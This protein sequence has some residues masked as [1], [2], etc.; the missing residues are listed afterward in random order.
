MSPLALAQL[1]ADIY[2]IT[3]GFTVYDCDGVYL[4]H[5]NIDNCDVFVF[6]GSANTEDWLDDFYAIPLKDPALGVVHSGM[7]RGVPEA[8]LWI[9]HMLSMLPQ[10]D[11]VILTGHSLGGAHARLMAGLLAADKNPATQLV[12][13]G[14][15]KPGCQLLKE[16]VAA[17]VEHLSYRHCE[18][19]V[20]TLPP[21]IFGYVHTEPWIELGQDP[22]SGILEPASD[23]SIHRY[24]EAL[25]NPDG[26]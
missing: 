25:G 23:H 9:K 15:P 22:D 8:Y 18:D 5:A 17:T 21:D 2:T 12:T 24:V 1:C 16:L 13:F 3:D 26:A 4:G 14:S 19:I 20:P 7:H 11:D 6:R 10:P